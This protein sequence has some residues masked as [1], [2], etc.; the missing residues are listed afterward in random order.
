MSCILSLTKKK[1]Q[2]TPL[3]NNLFYIYLNYRDF[4]CS[5]LNLQKNQRGANIQLEKNLIWLILSA[6]ERSESS[7]SLFEETIPPYCKKML[8]GVKRC[9]LRVKAFTFYSEIHK[10]D[11]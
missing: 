5:M 8:F 6:M 3:D 2:R 9:Q 1:F 4:V 11:N 10:F 7:S